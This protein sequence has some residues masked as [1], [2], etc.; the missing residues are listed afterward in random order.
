MSVFTGSVMDV[1][2]QLPLDVSQE[3]P[4]AFSAGS[5]DLTQAPV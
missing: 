2:F 5:L 1:G 4:P 3:S